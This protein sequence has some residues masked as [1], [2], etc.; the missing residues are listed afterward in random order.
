MSMLRISRDYAPL[1][2]EHAVARRQS[3]SN[4]TRRKPSTL[5]V[6]ARRYRVSAAIASSLEK[7]VIDSTNNGHRSQWSSHHRRS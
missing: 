5:A 1:K 6:A 3:L 2:I 7:M 4:G